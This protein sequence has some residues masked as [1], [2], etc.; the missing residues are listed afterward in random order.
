MNICLYQRKRFG[1][2][3]DKSKDMSSEGVL[4]NLMPLPLVLPTIEPAAV[5]EKEGGNI[6]LP[7]VI[8][9]VGNL[10]DLITEGAVH[11]QLQEGSEGEIVAHVKKNNGRK[12][13][14][15]VNYS[16]DQIFQDKKEMDD[17]FDKNYMRDHN[18]KWG[19]SKTTNKGLIKNM[20][21]S[22]ENCNFV[23]R[24]VV[25][26]ID[27]KTRFQK[28]SEEN[29]GGSGRI[30]GNQHS[31]QDNDNG[32]DNEDNNEHDKNNKRGLTQ[33]QKDWITTLF[34]NGYTTRGSMLDKMVEMMEENIA[35]T[36]LPDCKKV[37]TYLRT[38]QLKPRNEV[39]S[40][41][42]I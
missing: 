29:P 17:L 23:A 31:H 34:K 19:A 36:T 13:G 4:E 30:P 39:L 3:T 40:V 1:H 28:I 16:T 42:V 38:L 22:I 12:R 15:K 41:V 8:Q 14:R 37:Q 35:P 25:D 32:H 7:Q 33:E 20:K 10:N 5:E 11:V 21:C 9:T 6:V 2:W 24:I 26:A 18:L 27:G